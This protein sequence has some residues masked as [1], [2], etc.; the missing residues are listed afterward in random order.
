MNCHSAII[1]FRGSSQSIYV[2]SHNMINPVQ[3]VTTYHWLIDKGT[4]LQLAQS[5]LG[6]ITKF[7]DALLVAS[8]LT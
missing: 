3:I 4:A 6:G 7:V 2:Y 8:K 1:S 5:P